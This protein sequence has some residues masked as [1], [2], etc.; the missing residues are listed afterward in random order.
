MST[1]LST[2]SLTVTRRLSIINFLTF[3]RLVGCWRGVSWG[4]L[5]IF[6]V[7]TIIL[8]TLLLLVK[9]CFIHRR[10]YSQYFQNKAA[11][12]SIYHKIEYKFSDQFLS[13]NEK[14]D[15]TKT[16]LIWLPMNRYVKKQ[17]YQQNNNIIPY[18]D[19]HIPRN[20]N[21]SL[22]FKHTSYSCIVCCWRGSFKG[23][24]TPLSINN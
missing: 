14:V 16:R 3:S 23:I 8:E 24:R 13:T 6:N 5:I 9:H 12:H 15:H 4:I 22:F 17:M 7:Y 1:S 18:S 19:H 10:G 2:T 11:L 21:I 20:S